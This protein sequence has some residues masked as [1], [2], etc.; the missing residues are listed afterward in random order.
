MDRYEKARP[1]HNVYEVD[2]G[3]RLDAG[4]VVVSATVAVQQQVLNEW[5]DVSNEFVTGSVTVV[6]DEKVHFEMASALAGEQDVEGTYQVVVI[7]TTGSGYELPA[8]IPLHL[9]P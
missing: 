3:P 9:W 1:E 7:V 4:D 5:L 6:D 2:Y 8:T